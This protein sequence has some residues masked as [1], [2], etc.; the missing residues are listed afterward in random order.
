ME[1]TNTK[2]KAAHNLLS[3]G[4]IL[5]DAKHFLKVKDHPQFSVESVRVLCEAAVISSISAASDLSSHFSLSQSDM[6]YL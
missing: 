3:K 1:R 4:L 5:Q 2:G 6:T